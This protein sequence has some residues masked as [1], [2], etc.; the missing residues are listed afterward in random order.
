MIFYKTNSP[1]LSLGGGKSRSSRKTTQTENGKFRT[2]LIIFFTKHST[3]P[4]VVTATTLF[5][6]PS[7]KL[8]Y[9]KA[10][11]CRTITGEG[12]TMLFY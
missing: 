9:K 8:W 2:E 5:Q 4:R 1:L 11:N 7:N 6:I 12:C 3:T 10:S